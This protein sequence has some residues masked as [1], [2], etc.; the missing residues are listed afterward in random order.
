MKPLR[1]L[2]GRALLWLCPGVIAEINRIQGERAERDW[3][4]L[5]AECAQDYPP[6]RDENHR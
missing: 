2:I 1:P 6:M 4:A 3:D 5:I